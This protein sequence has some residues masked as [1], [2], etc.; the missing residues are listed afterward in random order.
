MTIADSALRALQEAIDRGDYGPG[1]RL[2]AERVLALE[3]GVG[4]STLR[5]ALEE[6]ERQGKVRRYVGRGTFVEMALPDEVVATLRLNPAPSPTD[7][8]ELRLMIEPQIAALAALRANAPDIA[9]LRDMTAALEQA[10]EWAEWERLDSQLHTALARTCRNPLLAGVLD[11]LN[12]IRGQ[13]EWGELRSTTLNPDRQRA[14]SQQHRAIVDALGA[15][16]PAGAAKAM[17]AHLAAVRDAMITG[18]PADQNDPDETNLSM[19]GAIN[20]Y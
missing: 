4:R 6:L 11:T 1:G 16:N 13:K 3:L 15:R 20:A 7:V 8:L 10:T 12:V 2:P 17:R 19:F 14:Y 5:K 18:A 9:R